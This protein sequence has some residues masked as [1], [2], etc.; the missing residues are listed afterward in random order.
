[1]ED[2][3]HNYAWR[4]V[5]Q[6][7]EIQNLQ[8]YL[9]LINKHLFIPLR[10]LVSN[11]SNYNILYVSMLSA[12]QVSEACHPEYDTSPSANIGIFPDASSTWRL[13][14]ILPEPQLTCKAILYTAFTCYA[15]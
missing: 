4:N 6:S 10:C 13:P 7:T 1:M 11:I 9:V 14:F 8:T 15:W 5:P 12:L 2:D 3:F